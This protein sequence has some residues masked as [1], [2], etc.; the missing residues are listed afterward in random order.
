ML[1][2]AQPIAATFAQPIAATKGVPGCAF[3]VG[4]HAVRQQLYLVSIR[5][6][7]FSEPQ[8]QELFVNALWLLVLCVPSFI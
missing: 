8:P 5:I 3:S 6:T 7:A 4:K 2:F 1:S